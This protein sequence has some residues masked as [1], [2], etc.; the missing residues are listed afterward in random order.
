[1]YGKAQSGI[2]NYIK[3]LTDHIFEL[4]K[5]NDYYLFLL[6]PVFSA[7]QNPHDRIHKIKVTSRW[8]SL[9]EQTKFL[10]AINKH[11]LDLMHFPHF[12]APIFYNKKRLVT[13]HDIIPKFFP[14][15]KQ[16]SWLRKKAYEL[17]ITTNLKKSAKIIADSQATKQD[18]INHFN[19]S[20]N[21]I[22]VINLGIEKHFKKIENYAKIKELKDKYQIAKP[23]IFFVS[24]WRNHKNFEGLIHAFEILKNKGNFDYQ[25]VLGGQ[26]DPNYPNIRQTI[27][28]S[29]YKN[30]IISPGFIA[31][32]EL[33]LFYNA[34]ELVAIPSFY[35]GFGLIGL[36][37]MACG[38]PV[39]SSNVTS[40]PEINGNAALYFD[41]KNTEQMAEK[42]YSVL[43][44][45]ELKNQLIAKGYQQIKKYSW[46]ECAQ[47]TLNLYNKILKTK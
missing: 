31:D 22:A 29:P 28:D 32:E 36:E 26:E 24:V 40:L 37:A 21:K 43:T 10:W 23:F 35:E 9:A 44:N 4:D 6:E 42:I 5:T 46:Q 25:L 27:N 12:N 34:A 33:P 8:Y 1:M 47:E 17:T 18:L 30:D 41:P 38:T 19:I 45:S 39:I 13:I 20:E 3:E 15:H 11:R 14:G 16:K 2:G 7:Y